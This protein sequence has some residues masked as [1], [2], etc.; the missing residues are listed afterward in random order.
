[1]SISVGT[2]IWLCS[3][4]KS[5]V[6]GEVTKAEV[7]KTKEV[8]HVKSDDGEVLSGLHRE[9]VHP[10][11]LDLLNEDV[12]DLLHL[13]ELHEATLL[14]CIQ[15]RYWRD[16]MYTNIGA[17]V[18]A[19]N[20][21]TVEIPW[22][23]DD[24]AEAYLKQKE[25]IEGLLPHSWA[26]AHN[27]Y[28]EMRSTGENQCVLISGESGAGKTE[29]AKIVMRYLGRLSSRQVA[30]GPKE[31]AE[32]V[33]KRIQ[34]ASPILEAFGNAKTVRN[35]N[36]SRFGKFMK[37]QFDANG[38]LVGAY[39]IK[40]L[41]EKS[42]IVTAA[43]DER[44]YHSFY[45]LCAG[46]SAKQYN[47]GAASTYQSLQCGGVIAIDGVDDSKDFDQCRQAM[48][49][50]GIG[51][52]EA[53]AIWRVVAS[54]LHLQ[55]VKFMGEEEAKIDASSHA[56]LA[57]A[58]TL[59]HVPQEGLERELVTTTQVARGETIVRK[60]GSGQAIAMRDG[61]SKALYDNLFTWLVDKINVTT[62][63]EA[64]CK[65][66]I[67]LLDIFGFE[68]FAS[69]SFEQLCINLAN[70]TLQG[71]YN[72][73]IFEK[74]MQECR[75]EGVD[76]SAVVFQ[77]NTP[78][79]LLVNDKKDGILKL[80]DDECS[81]G[82][83]TDLGFL[84]SVAKT[85]AK[86]PY[87]EK[88]PLDKTT[89]TIKHYAGSVS[90]EVANF[91]EKNKDALKDGMRQLMRE[92]EDP[93]IKELLPPPVDK[94]GR[95]AS[96]GSFFK[97]QLAQL[98]E[99]INST[100]PHWIR[101]IKPHPAKK[102]RMFDPVTVMNQMR[103]AGVL[104]TV[105]IRAAGFP[106]RMTFD[107]FV[108][109]YQIILGTE[110]VSDTKAA[111]ANILAASDV[112]KAEGQVGTTK[113]FM[114]HAAWAKVL[115]QRDKKLAAFVITLQRFGKGYHGRLQAGNKWCEANKARLKREREQALMRERLEA[116]ETEAR[117]KC[118]A[119]EVKERSQIQGKQVAAYE[120]AMRAHLH[121]AAIRVQ[122]MFR[123]W[124][125]RKRLMR[126]VVEQARAT[127]TSEMDLDI[128][129][130]RL[131]SAQWD[132]AWRDGD[133][134]GRHRRLAEL[135][136]KEYE[137]KKLKEQQR[138]ERLRLRHEMTV[139]SAQQK[140]QLSR[141]A[142]E[143]QRKE[144]LRREAQERAEREAHSLEM[145]RLQRENSRETTEKH[146]QARREALRKWQQDAAE[147]AARSEMTR[148][149]LR[150]HQRND[151]NMRRAQ[152]A[153]KHIQ[154]KKFQENARFWEDREQWTEKRTQFLAPEKPRFSQPEPQSLPSP[155]RSASRSYNPARYHPATPLPATP[156]V[157][158]PSYMRS[159]SPREARIET[160][161][162]RDAASHTFL[163]PISSDEES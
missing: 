136:D 140:E 39:T 131:R 41:L 3:P 118:E 129:R 116:E 24:Q 77:D 20:P 52:A 14:A 137:E 97:D 127:A 110:S 4:V 106:I 49:D 153:S 73:F 31:E 142:E 81:L 64:E 6:L 78:C 95:A 40:Y 28:Y 92:S 68:N 119:E 53:D 83:G 93:F 25:S 70:E 120:V 156:R 126:M 15:R 103:S 42:R 33:G 60:L 161:W 89:F 74:D 144:R 9:E 111:T 56:A 59:L 38:S 19:L 30:G 75:A 67:G 157:T 108:S 84:A 43:K 115:A 80:L 146:H 16:V 99:L 107:N 54:I 105:K 17:I 141:E 155:V 12:D 32:L 125:C 69:N 135:Q 66:W 151:A 18:V 61:L 154:E 159:M 1:M 8:Y 37:V 48:T 29:A 104:E 87:F 11:R 112:P 113:V 2:K 117:A 55:N 65:N 13:T 71:H 51:D 72:A 44:V 130:V 109:R 86:N 50:V 138:K 90:Y 35:D 134:K 124:R 148:A 26:T 45:Q 132:Q 62:N 22:Y 57:A 147:R 58:C 101:C 100:N 122:K 88:K 36:S 102:K 96:V 47:L 114:K 145:A 98:M 63:R 123:G 128:F 85:C 76:V 10:A 152:S 121:A 133:A 7:V 79:L 23:K 91:L 27:T 139:A 158:T 46:K 149:M 160:A 143:R 94:R 34:Q 162:L 82:K 150:E 163:E 21:F 5:W